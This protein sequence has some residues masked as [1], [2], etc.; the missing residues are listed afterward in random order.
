[1]PRT[2]VR[3]AAGLALCCLVPVIA[4]CNDDVVGPAGFCTVAHEISR[5]TLSPMSDTV[6]VRVPAR[7]A[8]TVQLL[9][10]AFGRRGQPVTGVP[11]HFTSSDPAVAEVSGSGAVLPLSPGTAEIT[12]QLCDE[13]E[14]ATIT[15][16]SAVASIAVSPP[17]LTA[18]ARDTVQVTAKA[19]DP[20]GSVVLDV[21]FAFSLSDPT[22]ARSEQLSDST[23]RVILL[24]SGSVR[25][26]ATAEGLSSAQT[27]QGDI[28]ALPRAL[29]ALDVGGDVTCGRIP[30][31]RGYCWGLGDIGQLGSPG[32]SVCFNDRAP[33]GPFACTLLPKRFAEDLEL[34][35][36]SVG[37][38]HAC[39]VTAQSRAYCWGKGDVGQLGNGRSGGGTPVPATVFSTLPFSSITV[40]GRHTCALSGGTAYCWGEDAFGQLGDSRTINSTT[41]IPVVGVNTFAQVSAG[42]RHTCGIT[43][44]GVAHCWG[45]NRQGQLGRGFFG[46]FAESPVGVAG[47]LTFAAISAGDSSH[48]CGITSSDAAYCW[49]ENRFGQLG[50]GST[51]WSASPVPVAGGLAFAEISAGREFTCGRT[52]GGTAYCWGRNDSG[53]LGNG[54]TAN[55][56]T[57]VPVVG[58]TFQSVSAGRR[59]ACG[60]ASDGNTYCWGSNVFGAL[61]NELQ[62]A[63]RGQPVLVA[64]PR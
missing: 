37:D 34:A 22:V 48:T 43:Q 3:C 56:L 62:A 52:K 42:Y 25:V 41:P 10:E 46:D 12:A 63:V 58:G 9:A 40:G 23:A 59:H 4:A 20:F 28:T 17:P 53:Q 6:L 36:V 60:V 26:I 29:L 2:P 27:Q 8:D 55:S 38:S 45:D 21:H 16:L 64:T 14:S 51:G 24:R 32:D 47:G 5:V 31:G 7:L 15:V 54:S 57:P 33:L 11:F 44:A 35:Q 50:N 19:L 13:K 39:A 61:G 30:M 49:G 18:V 1:M